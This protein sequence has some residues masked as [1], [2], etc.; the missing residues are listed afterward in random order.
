M[1]DLLVNPGTIM[2]SVRQNSSPSATFSGEMQAALFKWAVALAV[3]CAVPAGLMAL[4]MSLSLPQGK[5]AVHTVLETVILVAVATTFMMTLVQ[6][7]SGSEPSLP[8]IGLAFLFAGCLDGFHL[9]TG[10]GSMAGTGAATQIGPYA[11]SIGR[12]SAASMMLIGTGLFALGPRHRARLFSPRVNFAILI[13]VGILAW[14]LMLDTINSQLLPQSTFS[15]QLVKRPFDLAPLGIFVLGGLVVFPLYTLRR[16]SPFAFSLVLSVIPQ[17]AAQLYMLFASTQAMDSGATAAHLLKTFG[18]LAPLGGMMVEFYR[19]CSIRDRLASA[20][21]ISEAAVLEGARGKEEFLGAM[22]HEIRTPMN[23]VIGMTRLMKDTDLSAEQV[24]YTK[25]I[26][27]SANGLLNLLND[28]HDFSVVEAGRMELKIES[29]DLNKVFEDTMD[30][31]GLRAA[32]QKLQLSGCLHPDIPTA[33]IGDPERVRQILLNL[34]GNAVKFTEKGE[35]SIRAAQ[36]FDDGTAVKL[37]FEVQDSGIGIRPEDQTR[38]FQS[39]AQIGEPNSR[40]YSGSGLGLAITSELVKLMGGEIGVESELGEGS[41]FW[42]TVR[43]HK[44]AGAMSLVV[45]GLDELAT[46]RLVIADENRGN[47]ETVHTHLNAWGCRSGEVSEAWELV[48][49][50]RDAD[51]EASHIQVALIDLELPGMEIADLCEKLADDP[52][53]CETRLIAMAPIDKSAFTEVLRDGAF[54]AVLTKPIKKSLLRAAVRSV[55]GMNL[56]T[57]VAA[58]EVS[59]DNP[60]STSDSVAPRV[61]DEYADF[62]SANTEGVETVE[63]SPPPPTEL[64]AG[65]HVLLAEDNIVNQKVAGKALEKLGCKV[66]VVG[67]GTEAVSAVAGGAYDMVLM[68][69]QM[70]GMD[71]YEATETIRRLDGDLSKV[72]IIAMTANAMVGDRERCLESGMDDYVSKPFDMSDLERVFREWLPQL[73]SE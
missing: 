59:E 53:T 48:H 55:L 49:C 14:T 27:S 58:L 8:L 41:T 37:R 17:G 39:F 73:V 34:G 22:S 30:S 18:Y 32:E 47:R 10:M 7:R 21:T 24:E 33:L 5:D 4:G 26:T 13:G 43:L 25:A 57:A 64:A 9:F 35:I 50:L 71:G 6:H 38:L 46:T 56:E 29:F 42:F 52:A 69:C 20:L 16:P 67:N 68:D 12:V 60:A 63:A 31:L 1:T 19:T 3:I 61:L 66:D 54:S 40:R 72:P 44:Q 2:S 51:E 62:D 23:G 28:I 70:P 11:W 15:D 45:P 36:V 65:I